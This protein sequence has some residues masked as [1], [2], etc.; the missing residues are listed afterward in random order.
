MVGAGM[1]GFVG[2]CGCVSRNQQ[3]HERVPC[4]MGCPG[5]CVVVME[6]AEMKL[7]QEVW[8]WLS[9][10]PLQ[11]TQATARG[12]AAQHIPLQQIQASCP[13]HSPGCPGMGARKGNLP[14]VSR[15]GVGVGLVNPALDS[16]DSEVMWNTFDFSCVITRAGKPLAREVPGEGGMFGHGCPAES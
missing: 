16:G 12:N 7:H 3:S 8:S 6:P 10:K 13:V 5:L 14:G 1:A 4:E 2:S 11:Q 15:E 9:S